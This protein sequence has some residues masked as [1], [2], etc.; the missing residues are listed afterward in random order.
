MHTLREIEF[1]LTHT[2]KALPAVKNKYGHVEGSLDTGLTAGRVGHAPDRRHEIFE[3]VTRTLLAQIIASDDQATESVFDLAFAPSPT[4]AQVSPF[5]IAATTSLSPSHASAGGFS[6]VRQPVSASAAASPHHQHSASSSADH[7]DDNRFQTTSSL[8]YSIQNTVQKVVGHSS[9]Y[10]DDFSRDPKHEFASPQRNPRFAHIGAAAA[11][12]SAAAAAIPEPAFLL[13]DLR[14]EEEYNACHIRAAGSF[15]AAMLRQDRLTA[16]MVRVR[17]DLSKVLILY[18]NDERLAQEAA[19]VFIGKQFPCVAVL[20]GGMARNLWQPAARL[21]LLALF[22]IRFLSVSC[23]MFCCFFTSAGL[24]KFAEK[25]PDLVVGPMAMSFQSPPKATR[26]ARHSV[27]DA[28]CLQAPSSSKLTASS[29][30]AASASSGAL[31]GVRRPSGPPSFMG[32]STSIRSAATGASAMSRRTTAS[33]AS[34]ASRIATKSRL[35]SAGAAMAHLHI[36]DVAPPTALERLRERALA[37][38]AS[39]YAQSDAAS[40]AS[41]GFGRR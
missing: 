39:V 4:A 24:P 16:A 29:L 30:A 31:A 35:V 34:V 23:S 8:A 11:V 10:G 13:L 7:A 15:P 37:E 25:F 19:K 18:D 21:S 5:S 9:G 1:D 22:T 41:H 12:K 2:Q 27:H 40:V 17:S 38:S 36:A 26:P 28:M 6:P 20:T 33:G 14:T 3:R 32:G